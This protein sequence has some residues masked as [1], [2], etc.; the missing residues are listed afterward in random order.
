MISSRLRAAFL[1]P[2]RELSTPPLWPVPFLSCSDKLP[3]RPKVYG[4]IAV[5]PALDILPKKSTP[6][7]GGEAQ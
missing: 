2:K 1:Y 7:P 4:G 5:I 6:A 3:K